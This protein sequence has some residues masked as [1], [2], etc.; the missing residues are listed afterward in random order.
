[1]FSSGKRDDTARQVYELIVAKARQPALYEDL[2]IADTFE[3]RFDML[4][5]LAIL[6]M[7]RLGEGPQEARE[8]GQALFDAMF[9]DMDLS[10]REMGVGD[11]SVGKRVRKLAGIFSGRAG[12]YRDAI[13]SGEQ[14]ELYRALKR[15]IFPDGV[16][17]PRMNQLTRY[18]AECVAA[19][20]G[21][22]MTD[23]ARGRVV[24]P[25]FTGRQATQ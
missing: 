10:L 7:R 9:R 20:E 1:L 5:L 24:L 14:G 23:L 16:A 6:V 2:G 25:S 12:A 8:L 3:G 18:V 17:A 22:P 4:A 21:Q 15:N 19:L 11:L 13:A